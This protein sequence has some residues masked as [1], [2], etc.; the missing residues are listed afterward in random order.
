MFTNAQTSSNQPN[1]GRNFK[2]FFRFHPS[3]MMLSLFAASMFIA[4][5]C[6]SHKNTIVNAAPQ[7][8]SAVVWNLT[9]LRGQEVTYQKG[10]SIATIQINPESGTFSGSNGCNRYFGTVKLLPDNRLEFSEF[11]GTKMACPENFRKL[12]RDF[13]QLL[14]RCNAYNLQENSLQLLQ[15]D[16]VLLTFE[17]SE[18]VE[19]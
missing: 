15:D 3:L 12:E 9:L 18:T 10:Q 11:N 1:S 7:F 13:M 19:D 17:K 4:C 8:N 6:R 16:K 14:Q 2:S 5:G